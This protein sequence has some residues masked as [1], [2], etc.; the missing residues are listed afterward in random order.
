MAEIADV[1]ALETITVE[2][3][4]D[5]RDRTIQRYADVTERATEN[6]TPGAGDLSYLEDSGDVDVYHS[7]AWRHIGDPVGT[8]KMNAGPTAPIG[9]LV[10]NGSAV[11]RTTYAALFAAIGEAWGAGD[12]STTF[13]LPDFRGRY[14]MGVAASGTGNTLAALFGSIN[15]VHTG[16]SHVHGNPSTSSDSH[17][18]TQGSTGAAV[19]GADTGTQGLYEGAGVKDAHT[20]TNPSTSS[21]SHSHTQGNTNA[22]GTANTGSNN[23]P[24]ATVHFLIKT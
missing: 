15:H 10:C 11:S 8:L 3:G 7:G 21:D 4:N 5:I 16:P 2:W 1:V 18:H 24:T 19:P 12:G 9:C 20:H 6:A 13:N 17:S 14:P 22:G 23:P